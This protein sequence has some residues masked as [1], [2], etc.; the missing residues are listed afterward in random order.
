MTN[1]DTRYNDVEDTPQDI[2]I[3]TGKLAVPLSSI[4]KAIDPDGLLPNYDGRY[5]KKDEIDIMFGDAGDVTE[6][7][8]AN[9]FARLEVLA[10]DPVSPVVGRM[11]I[12]G[13]GV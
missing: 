1:F 12:L 7:L 3:G 4:K 6:E 5:Y 13:G 11:W 8:V 10:S 9:N 2:I